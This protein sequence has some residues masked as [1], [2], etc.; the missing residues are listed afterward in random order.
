[1]W[2]HDRSTP[3]PSAPDG[4]AGPAFHEA[5]RRGDWTSG[6]AVALQGGRAVPFSQSPC[7]VAAAHHAACPR[8]MGVADRRQITVRDANVIRVRDRKPDPG[9]LP[10]P[11]PPRG[12]RRRDPDRRAGRLTRLQRQESRSPAAGPGFERD[13]WSRHSD[14]NRGPAVYETAA[15][16][17][18]YVGAGGILAARSAA[19][20]RPGP[21]FRRVSAPPVEQLTSAVTASRH[22]GVRWGRGAGTRPGQPLDG[23]DR[24]GRCATSRRRALSRA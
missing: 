12:R 3:R 8:R 16:P 7:P 15:L 4:R 19:R 14:L 2:G 11:V 17:L 18:S 22:L 20:E 9:Q 10:V 13:R 6:T 5:D 24:R 21:S 23:V 1:M